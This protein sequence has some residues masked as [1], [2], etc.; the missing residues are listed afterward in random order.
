MLSGFLGHFSGGPFAGS[1]P[2]SSSSRA[3][4][5]IE[6]HEYKGDFKSGESPRNKSRVALKHDGSLARLMVGRCG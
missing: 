4:N 6:T 1:F 2:G 3:D 5:V